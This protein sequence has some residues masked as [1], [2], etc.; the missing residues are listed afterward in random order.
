MYFE[1]HIREATFLSSRKTEVTIRPRYR[2]YEIPHVSSPQTA[3]PDIQIQS[4]YGYLQLLK[5][6]DQIAPPGAQSSSASCI[7][8]REQSYHTKRQFKMLINT[9]IQKS[10]L[11]AYHVEKSEKKQFTH[12]IS[13]T[14]PLFCSLKFSFHLK[15]TKKLKPKTQVYE[16]SHTEIASSCH[17]GVKLKS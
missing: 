6:G 10:I 2:N 7:N 12:N 9:G 15:K 5:L 1:V 8:T 4:F 13:T 17:S 11:G 3:F 14:P 16:I